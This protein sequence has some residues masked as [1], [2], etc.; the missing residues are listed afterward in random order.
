MTALSK[1]RRKTECEQ[2]KLVKSFPSLKVSKVTSHRSKI[3]IH[4]FAKKNVLKS[5]IL[6]KHEKCDFPCLNESISSFVSFI[7]K[8][9]KTYI[10]KSLDTMHIDEILNK[11]DLTYQYGPFLGLSRLNRWNRAEELGLCPPINVKEILLLYEGYN[12]TVYD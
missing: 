8:Q 5:E 12:N 10:E 1:K 9:N 4:N 2:K 11:F 7:E 3:H 6:E